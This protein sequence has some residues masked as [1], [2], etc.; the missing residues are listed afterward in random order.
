M[1][2]HLIFFDLTSYKA[3]QTKFVYAPF[4]ATDLC[5]SIQKILI[6]S[7]RGFVFQLAYI[8][9][10]CP[11]HPPPLLV[12]FLV[13]EFQLSHYIKICTYWLEIGWFVC[14]S[15]L[16]Y[17]FFK[18]QYS[19]LI[20]FYKMI[21]FTHHSSQTVCMDPEGIT[22]HWIDLNIIFWKNDYA[23]FIEKLWYWRSSSFISLGPLKNSF[24]LVVFKMQ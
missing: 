19:S 18:V 9:R 23:A 22:L 20:W 10:G 24:R 6:W 3:L 2:R 12:H 16:A 14:Q 11:I 21:W 7:C 17:A 5:N 15:P 4:K 1:L 13:L 8:F